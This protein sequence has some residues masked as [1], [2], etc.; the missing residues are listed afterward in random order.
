MEPAAYRGGGHLFTVI[1]FEFINSSVE[2]KLL[3]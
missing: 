2:T 3:T 1:F